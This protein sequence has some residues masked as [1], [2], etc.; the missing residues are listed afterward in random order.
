MYENQSREAIDNRMHK[1]EEIQKDL[2]KQ[3]E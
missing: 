3:I 1:K 2:L